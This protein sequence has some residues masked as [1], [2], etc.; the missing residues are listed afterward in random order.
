MVGSGSACA[1]T[2]RFGTSAGGCLRACSIV[3]LLLLSDKKR[4]AAAD[5][6]FVGTSG[7]TFYEQTSCK[8]V[9]PLGF[10]T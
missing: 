4:A 7:Y 9:V 5:A 6:G 10:N 2:V 3:L 8:Q 1:M